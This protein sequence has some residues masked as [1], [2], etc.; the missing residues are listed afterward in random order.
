MLWSRPNSEAFIALLAIPPHLRSIFNRLNSNS[1]FTRF[2]LFLQQLPIS[3]TF[4]ATF[5]H[6][7]PTIN[8]SPIGHQ[9]LV[10]F[11]VP[12]TYVLLLRRDC[13]KRISKFVAIMRHDL[14]QALIAITYHNLSKLLRNNQIRAKFLKI[15]TARTKT[16]YLPTKPKLET[17]IL[18]VYNQRP[19][20]AFWRII[21]THSHLSKYRYHGPFLLRRFGLQMH[22]NVLK[23]TRKRFLQNENSENKT[24]YHDGNTIFTIWLFFVGIVPFTLTKTWKIPKTMGIEPQNATIHSR[25]ESKLRIEVNKRNCWRTRGT[26]LC[27]KTTTIQMRFKQIK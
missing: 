12:Y 7:S 27:V 24:V 3:I 14:A 19:P 13:A 17:C 11:I 9:S 15:Y 8:F 25:K 22:N 1:N 21:L 16:W 4:T 10:K 2:I 18:H 5:Q 6:T 20:F 26:I 23:T